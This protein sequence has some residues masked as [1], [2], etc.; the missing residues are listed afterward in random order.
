MPPASDDEGL[1]VGREAEDEEQECDL[2][3][4]ADY[5]GNSDD[6]AA[7]FQDL[8]VTHQD[9]YEQQHGHQQENVAATTLDDGYSLSSAAE[10]KLPANANAPAMCGAPPGW[11]PP[12]APNCWTPPAP[13]TTIGEPLTFAEVDNPGKWAEFTFRPKHQ[14]KDRKASE[15]V[16]HASPCSATPVPADEEGNR[17]SNGFDFFY[18]GWKRGDYDPVFRNS[19]KGDHVFPES[20][21][22]GL[23]VEKLTRL[24][25]TKERMLNV[26][27]LAPDALWFYQLLLPIHDIGPNGSGVADDPRIT[28]YPHVALCTELH[29]ITDLKLRGSGRGHS[30]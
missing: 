10:N 3:C 6:E 20:R 13:N 24:G 22:G 21:K 7:A 29:A 5:D 11:K 19:S 8:A 2:N 30:F 26:G 4:L 14:M 25:L 9:I 16:C 17:S 23:D 15:C 18:D 12:R 28:C 1:T 27:D